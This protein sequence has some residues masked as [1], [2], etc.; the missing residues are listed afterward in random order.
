MNLTGMTKQRAGL[1]ASRLTPREA[2]ACWCF[3]VGMRRREVAKKMGISIKTVD[4]FMESVRD[5][6]DDVPVSGIPF[7]MLLA[8]GFQWPKHLEKDDGRMD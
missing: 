6:L 5:K 7:I 3:T 4:V 1:L 2:E 8:F